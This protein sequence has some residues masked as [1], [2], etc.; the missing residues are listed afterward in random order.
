MSTALVCWALFLLTQYIPPVVFPDCFLLLHTSSNYFAYFTFLVNFKGGSS[1]YSQSFDI[2][3][4]HLLV[5]GFFSTSS[6]LFLSWR[7]AFQKPFYLYSA[8]MLASVIKQPLVSV[9]AE[10]SWMWDNSVPCSSAVILQ[11]FCMQIVVSLWQ[12]FLSS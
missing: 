10:V 8:V 9:E 4:I 12:Y 7:W 2:H 11:F 5:F 3:I 6:D 1:L